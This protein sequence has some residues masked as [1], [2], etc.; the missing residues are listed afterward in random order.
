[1]FTLK[2]KAHTWVMDLPTQPPHF[3]ALPSRRLRERQFLKVTR[4][5][6]LLLTQVVIHLVPIMHGQHS[7]LGEWHTPLTHRSCHAVCLLLLQKAG[8]SDGMAHIPS[9][10][11]LPRAGSKSQ[12]SH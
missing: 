10:N 4:C 12:P 7:P 11:P 1:M 2:H 6:S 3:L 9:R 8:P 5:T